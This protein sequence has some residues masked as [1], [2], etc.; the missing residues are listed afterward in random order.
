MEVEVATMGYRTPTSR[1]AQG[2]LDEE[3][4]LEEDLR[5][6]RNTMVF[7]VHESESSPIWETVAS[8]LG[9]ETHCL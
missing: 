9:P 6:V 4:P 8:T 7:M 2:A 5:G 1:L 3:H